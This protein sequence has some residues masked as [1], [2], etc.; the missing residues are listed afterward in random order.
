MLLWH[1]KTHELVAAFVAEIPW[2]T[3]LFRSV[4][5]AR[6]VAR[7]PAQHAVPGKTHSASALIFKGKP[8]SGSIIPVNKQP[9]SVTLFLACS[10]R[11][12]D[13]AFHDSRAPARRCT[14]GSPT[15]A[16]CLRSTGRRRPFSFRTPSHPPLIPDSNYKYMELFMIC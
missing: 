2:V 16:A 1:D 6:C 10:R 11:G 12:A 15:H 9:D 5:P 3:E 13:R 7:S 4:F 8:E 14:R